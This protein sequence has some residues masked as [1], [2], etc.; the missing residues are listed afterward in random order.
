[1]IGSGQL[2]QRIVIE[3][4]TT[5]EDK[6]GEE[7]PSGW[8]E[9]ATRWAQKEV[10]SDTE[11]FA[12]EHHHGRRVVRWTMRYDAT[13]EDVD[14]TMR[15]VHGGTHYEVVAAHDPDGKRREFVIVTEVKPT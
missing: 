2:D 3:Q 11:S 15:I 4:P 5:A 1:M 8:S 7:T 14:R 12:A 6:Y 10:E 13:L 9:L